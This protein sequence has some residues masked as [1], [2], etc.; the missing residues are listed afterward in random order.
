V[1]R[2]SCLR[3]L[4]AHQPEIHRV[5][6]ESG[7]TPRLFI[8]YFKSNCWVNLRILGRLCEFY[9][10]APPTQRPKPG[11]SPTSAR[12]GRGPSVILPPPLPSA[13]R[14]PIRR[15]KSSDEWQHALVPHAGRPARVRDRGAPWGG[16]SRGRGLPL[17]ADTH[18]NALNH[19]YDSMHL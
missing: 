2:A 16:P 4:T 7:S 18:L 19:I 8:G 10:T 9:L 15:A 3:A 14:I 5:D 13:S 1:R 6:P 11:G 17:S 12:L